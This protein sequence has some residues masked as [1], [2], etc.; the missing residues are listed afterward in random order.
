MLASQIRKKCKC[1]DFLGC[2]PLDKPPKAKGKYIINT[3]THNL[4]GE[5][6]IAV[7]NGYMFDPFGYIYPNWLISHLLKQNI[8]PSYNRKMYQH[9][10]HNTCALF[11]LYYLHFGTINLFHGEYMHN[12]NIVDNICYECS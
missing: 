6:W 5:H 7:N 12:L 10:L 3:Q 11:C 4:P 9:P 1:T 2:F 8:H